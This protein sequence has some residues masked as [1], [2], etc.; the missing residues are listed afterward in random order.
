MIIDKQY[1]EAN[2]KP[3]YERGDQVLIAG[4]YVYQ[5]KKPISLGTISNALKGK[6]VNAKVVAIILEYYSRK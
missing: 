3:K 6:P 2:I 5:F 4:Q 1:Y